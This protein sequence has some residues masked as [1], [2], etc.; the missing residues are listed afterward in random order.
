MK[1]V[2]IFKRKLGILVLLGV[3]GYC[4]V[5]ALAFVKLWRMEH[6][7]KL[8]SEWIFE[9][10]PAGS[11]IASPHWDDKVPVGLPGKDSAIYKMHGREYE[12][13]VYER[14][15]GQMIDSI[16]KRV[17][18]SDYLTFATPRAADSIPRIPDE[19]PN[20]TAL[21]RLLWGEKVGF[22]L[23]HT[24]KNR[25]SFLGITFNDDLADES[26]S[27]YDHPKVVVFKNE[28]KLSA[29]E[30][31]DRVK[32][33]TRYEPLPNMNDMLLMD[34]GGW[35][36]AKQVWNPS[37]NYYIRT[38]VFTLVIAFSTWICVGGLFRKLPDGGLGLS[39]LVGL[40]GATG[41]H[42]VFSSFN[43]L[44]YTKNG[45]V[46]VAL[47]L[48]SGAFSKIALSSSTRQRVVDSIARHGLGVLVSVFVGTLVI[49]LIVIRNIDIVITDIIDRHNRHN[50]HNI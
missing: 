28:E 12:L 6:P 20:M 36:A 26:F 46:F 35:I 48:I 34:Q 3:V 11:R 18:A 49:L 19:Y 13:P 45:G 4:L 47:L 5:Y 38:V 31:L 14:D 21:L 41:I 43:L 9:N 44:P 32:N 27:V 42:W 7:Y 37:W 50:Q 22:K 16:V 1:P 15:S 40:L 39:L 30:I 33:V 29:E 8:A 24:T 17:A 2:S 25:P 10:V 23:V